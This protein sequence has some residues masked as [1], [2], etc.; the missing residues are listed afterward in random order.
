MTKIVAVAGKG[1]TGKTTFAALTLRYLTEKGA[2]A[3]LAV[4]ADPNANLHEALGVT[5]STVVADILDDCK[6]GTRIPPGMSKDLF[7]EYRLQQSLVEGER[8]D[9][10][11]MGGPQGPGCYCYPNDLLR[12]YLERLAANYDFLVVDAEAGLEHLS[13]QTIPRADFLFVMSDATVRG[14][15][16]AGRIRALVQHLK[17]P[18]E[19]MGLVI[20]RA[21][22]GLEPLQAE[23]AAT[24]LE[25]LGVIP[26]DEEIERR[27]LEGQPLLT[28]PVEAPSV[29]AASAILE[30]VGLGKAGRSA[31]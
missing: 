22:D 7:I 18:I 30:R 9:L 12:R 28:L 23:I 24:G 29:R 5:V 11:V 1:G 31:S 17:T 27:D 15:R 25:L 3:L 8:I 10:L 13:R 26:W 16:S 20:T 6:D 21:A 19:R 2:G 4:D 14:V